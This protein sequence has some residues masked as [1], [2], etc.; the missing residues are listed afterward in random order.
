VITKRQL[1][2]KATDDCARDRAPAAFSFE[3]GQCGGCIGDTALAGTS[4]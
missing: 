4:H 2:G 3:I 1:F